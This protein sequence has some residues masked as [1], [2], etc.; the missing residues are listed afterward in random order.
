MEQAVVLGQLLPD[1]QVAPAAPDQRQG[2]QLEDFARDDQIEPFPF[3][4]GTDGG[5]PWQDV[6]LEEAGPPARCPDDPERIGFRVQR[7]EPVAEKESYV[8][9]SVREG[10]AQIVDHRVLDGWSPA[11][12]RGLGRV[13]DGICNQDFHGTHDGGATG[14]RNPVAA[15]ERLPCHGRCAGFRAED[16]CNPRK[17]LKDRHGN[18]GGP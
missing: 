5:A 13:W 8:V 9:P 14:N 4:E 7:P 17:R 1:H 18:R 2:V 15:G 10:K 16:S 11:D 3:R 6:G 12:A